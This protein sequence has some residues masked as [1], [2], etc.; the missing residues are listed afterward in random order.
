MS[1]GSPESNPFWK[2]Y[3]IDTP[4]IRLTPIEKPDMSS[5]LVRMTGKDKIIVIHIFDEVGR[6]TN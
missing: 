1:L 3:E 5:F 4:T 6:L 2:D